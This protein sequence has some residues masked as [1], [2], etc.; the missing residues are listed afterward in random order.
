MFNLFRVGH[1]ASLLGVL[2]KFGAEEPMIRKLYY[3]S[4]P[5]ERYVCEYGLTDITSEYDNPVDA[6]YEM[7]LKL[8]ELKML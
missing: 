1:L 7:I 6:C 5:K 4:E 8:H 3:A 2:P